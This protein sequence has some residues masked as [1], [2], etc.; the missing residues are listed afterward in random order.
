MKDYSS[1]VPGEQSASCEVRG[2]HTPEPWHQSGVITE[3]KRVIDIGADDN[4]NV[5]QCLT[6]DNV[7]GDDIAKANARRIVACVNACKGIFTEGLEKLV[8][9]L[10]DQPIAYVG[11]KQQRDALAEALRE[12]SQASLRSA[13]CWNAMDSEEG[14]AGG[15]IIA[16]RQGLDVARKKANALLSAARTPANHE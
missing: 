8:A 14:V 4:S 16:A 15:D 11:M 2:T 6:G 3:I 1:A 7:G 10:A 12:L 13:Q 9:G 5:A